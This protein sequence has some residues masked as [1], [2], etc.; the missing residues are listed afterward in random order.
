[1]PSKL[2]MTLIDE[3]AITHPPMKFNSASTQRM[4]NSNSRGT[5]FCISFSNAS[6][7]ALS[8]ALFFSL[9]TPVSIVMASAVTLVP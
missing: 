8:L 7:L 5:A 9:Q 2:K 6:T 4:G 1:M 3:A